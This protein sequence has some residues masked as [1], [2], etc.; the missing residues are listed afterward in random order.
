MPSIEFR[1][2]DLRSD[3]SELLQGR[4]KEES[5]ESLQSAYSL[6]FIQLGRK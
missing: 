4:I 3:S 1:K 6:D 5:A 2:D